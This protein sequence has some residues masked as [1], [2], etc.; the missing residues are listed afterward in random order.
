[1]ASWSYFGEKKPAKDLQTFTDGYAQTGRV[2]I[3]TG[4]IT[5]E[6]AAGS[7]FYSVPVAIKAIDKDGSEKVFA[8]CYTARLSDPQIQDAAFT[9]MHI[10]SGALKPAKARRGASHATAALRPRARTSALTE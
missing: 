3:E 4:D 1:M 10:E 7:V 8:G 6:G 9:P 5:Q 2:E